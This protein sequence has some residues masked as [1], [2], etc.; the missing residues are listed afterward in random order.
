MPQPRKLQDE[1]FR[2]AKAEGFAARSAY[3]LLELHE[4]KNLIRRGDRVLDLGCAPGSWLQAAERIMG[5]TGMILGVDLQEVRIAL[6][7]TVR[8]ERADA[9]TLDLSPFLADLG[10]MCRFD[11]VLSD[12]APNTSGHGDDFLS[13]R[14]CRRVLEF[15]PKA[16]RPGGRLLMKVLE[17]EEFPQLL[18]ETKAMFIEAGATKPRASREVSRETF[19]WGLGFLEDRAVD[20]QRPNP[21]SAG[22]SQSGAVSD[23]ASG[24]VHT[25][26]SVAGP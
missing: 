9:F 16:L 11:V 19:I 18:K 7:P 26:G 21:R 24:P 10:G 1:F 12:M 17:G 2:K 5:E 6:G 4:K 25:P 3:K 23:G 8:V 20:V 13:V 14:L 22:H 15:L